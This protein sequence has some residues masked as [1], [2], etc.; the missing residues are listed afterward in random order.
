MTAFDFGQPVGAVFQYAYTVPDAAAA[1][2]SWTAKLGIGPWFVRG[3]FSPS[4]AR[5]RGEPSGLTVTLARAFSGHVMVELVHQHDD[6]PSVY[7]ELVDR[8]GYGFHH[9]AV[10]VQD[11]DAAVEHY[12]HDGH[13]VAFTDT[14]PT[15]ARISYVDTSDVLPGMVELVEMTPAQEEIYTRIHLASIGWDG[16]DPVREG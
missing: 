2:T 3:P 6:G 4:N 7:R 11:L 12:R 15:G 8:R 13:D 14:L 10:G 5:Y 9:W 16:T 1:M